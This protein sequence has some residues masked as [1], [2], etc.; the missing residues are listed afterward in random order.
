MSSHPAT[1]AD[2]PAFSLAGE[3]AGVIRTLALGFACLD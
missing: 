1:T 2:S 3:P